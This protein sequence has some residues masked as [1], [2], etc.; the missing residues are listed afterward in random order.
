MVG[1]FATAAS[2]NPTSS[3]SLQMH[4]LESTPSTYGDALEIEFK[5]SGIP[6]VRE[7]NVRA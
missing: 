7:D 2:R 3:S 5:K 1:A 4:V 6:Y